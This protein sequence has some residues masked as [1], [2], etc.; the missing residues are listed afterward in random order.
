MLTPSFRAASVLALGLGAGPAFVENWSRRDT[1]A[2]FAQLDADGDGFVTRADVSR[3][4]GAAKRFREFDTNRD[5]RLDRA[6]FAA[7]I[8][9]LN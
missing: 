9:A 1:D 2:R 8:A 4:P 5:G 7:L 6:E 3:V